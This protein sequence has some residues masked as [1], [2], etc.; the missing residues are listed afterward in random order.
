ME[1]K[2]I[3]AFT[4]SNQSS[5]G[6]LEL[7]LALDRS[8]LDANYSVCFLWCEAECLKYLGPSLL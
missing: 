7:P 4:E 1:V 3:F 6:V 5:L 2:S 8:F